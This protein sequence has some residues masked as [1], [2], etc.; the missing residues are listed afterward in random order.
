MSK[1]VVVIG[2]IHACYKTFLSLVDKIAQKWPN[3]QIVSVGD[4]VDRGP[5]SQSV[6]QYIIDNKIPCVQG[7]H[8]N[9]MF[10]DVLGNASPYEGQ[11]YAYQAKETLE[12]YGDHQKLKEHAEW[13]S[14]LPLFLEFKDSVRVGD[15]RDHGRSRHLVLS[16]ASI[17]STWKFRDPSHEKH[18]FFVQQALWNRDVPDDQQDIYN[19]FGHSPN[20]EPKIKSFFA[21]VDTGCVFNRSG[22][23]NLTAIHFPSLEVLQQGNIE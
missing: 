13:M 10:M 23:T 19:I 11:W 20:K 21:N 16:H 8:E 18:H 4:L 5:D 1:E 3:A 22:Y 17:G 6:V 2:D 7:N 14:K 9:M 12:S 15:D